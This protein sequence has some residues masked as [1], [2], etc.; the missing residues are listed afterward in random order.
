MRKNLSLIFLIILLAHY[1]YSQP[2]SNAEIIRQTIVEADLNNVERYLEFL[3]EGYDPNGTKL[4]PLIIF[5]HGQGERDD[6]LSGAYKVAKLGLPKLIEEEAYNMC[7]TVNGEEKCFIVISPQLQTKRSSGENLTTWSASF[8]NSVLN[9]VIANYKVDL[10]RIYLTG[11]SMGGIGVYKFASS[12]SNGPN[13]LAASAPIAA[14]GLND[15]QGCTISERRINLRHF[16]G[17]ADGTIS[18]ESGRATFDRI[19]N[20]TTPA[21]NADLRF[22]LYEG[23]VGHNKTPNMAHDSTERLDGQNIYEWFLSHTLGD[24]DSINT[25]PVVDAGADL[26]VTLPLDTIQI[27]GTA[28]DDVSITSHLWTQVSGN[29]LTI[30]GETSAVIQLTN[31]SEGIFEFTLTATDN[32]GLSSSDNVL[33]TINA[34]IENNP[35]VADAGNDLTITLSMDSVVFN[36]TGTDSDGIINNYLWSQIS[37]AS[38]LL[39]NANSTNLTITNLIEGTFEFSFTVTDDDGATSSDVVSLTVEPES[40]SEMGVISE[41]YLASKSLPYLEYLPAN[42]NTSGEKYP[43]LIYFHSEAAK[44]LD[45]L[46]LVRQE[47]PFYFMDQQN[48]NFC[49]TING[50]EKCFI[51]IAPQVEVGKGFFKGKVNALYNEI[52]SAYHSDTSQIYISGYDDGANGMLTRLLDA[53]NNPNR[54]AG[55]AAA[56][57]RISTSLDPTAIGALQPKFWMAHSNTDNQYPISQ[58][59]SFYNDLIASNPA[60]D[61]FF[62]TYNNETQIQTMFKAFDPADSGSFYH[63]LFNEVTTIPD[64]GPLDTPS[65]VTEKYIASRSLPYLEYLP[66]NYNTNGDRYPVLIYFHSKAAKG[67]DSLELVKQ[68]GPFYFITQENKEFCFTIDGTEQCFIVVAPQVEVGKGFS[69]G[70]VNAMY[71]VIISKY[72]SDSSEIYISGADDGANGIFYRLLDAENSPNRFAGVG[73][74]GLSVASS[75]NGPTVGLINP[76][77]WMAHSNTDA[78][79]F[80]QGAL[81][82]YNDVRSTSTNSDTLFVTYDSISHEESISRA[83]DPTGTDSMYDWLFSNLSATANREP[84]NGKEEVNRVSVNELINIKKDYLVTNSS[85]HQL[86]NDLNSEYELLIIDYSG[87]IVQKSKIKNAVNRFETS[88]NGLYF[89][90]IRTNQ[91]QMVQMG[92][93]LK[94]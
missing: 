8:T 23:N 85:L 27:N 2:G 36:G 50:Q 60:K 79:F 4:H 3:P 59:R 22:V 94:K 48:E 32:E 67:T 53:E 42:Y 75:I 28:T 15:S 7:Y 56:G 66:P 91:N 33:I 34:P 44:G 69:K 45:T 26:T 58:A 86:F 43:V 54:F 62:V 84:T 93:I 55:I 37:G 12:G 29:P 65:T 70:K 61:T 89:Y 18:P 35:P 10:N 49:F 30:S 87:Q 71:D 40:V 81:D 78:L 14:I 21:P 6:N 83:F 5:L 47:G 68:E 80:Y 76:K 16:H 19:V 31:L 63:W 9:H 73:V 52:L 39:L 11:H 88:T 25:A 24:N 41:R 46:D 20:C 72:H 57:A 92:R 64:P 13:R 82:F 17:E 74:A 51:V 1:G 90:K 77:L 38:L